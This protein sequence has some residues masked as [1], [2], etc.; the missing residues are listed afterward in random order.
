M[1]IGLHL[2]HSMTKLSHTG[3]SPKLVMKFCP[4]L[5]LPTSIHKI[6]HRLRLLSK[7][8]VYS[9]NMGKTKSSVSKTMKKCA[10]PN[11]NLNQKE[12]TINKYGRPPFT[13][14]LKMTKSFKFRLQ[15]SGLSLNSLLISKFHRIS[16]TAHFQ[17]LW[18]KRNKIN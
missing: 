10:K 2:R 16:L 8:K 7:S 17:I 1:I 12:K 6:L 9:T 4:H 13:P 11:Y 18:R 5:V 3:A 14:F 15:A